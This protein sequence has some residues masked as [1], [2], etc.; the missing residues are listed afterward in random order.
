MDKFHRIVIKIGTSTITHENGGLNLR[1]IERLVRCMSDIKNSGQEVILV[2]S[3]A[4]GAGAGRLKI[5]RPKEVIQKQATAAVGQCILMSVYDRFF[6]EYGHTVAQILLSRD[7]A[8]DI[9]SRDNLTNTFV[10]LLEMGVIPIVNENDSVSTDELILSFSENDALSAIV[11]KLTSAD[12]L[13]ML[14]DTDG[15]YDRN[16]AEFS[17]AKLITNVTEITDELLSSAS[18][19]GKRGTGG[20]ATKLS[21]VKTV[22]EV[23]ISAA[24]INGKNPELIY[25]VLDGKNAG[26]LFKGKKI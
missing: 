18:G 26:T 25:D 20:M 4:V 12:M 8:I 14:T 16:P 10:S 23:G 17:D 6:S 2:S 24:I 21:A 9:A 1:V 11:A 22:T 5:P 3:G 19:A 7:S 13:I 15:L